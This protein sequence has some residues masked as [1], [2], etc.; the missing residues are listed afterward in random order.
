MTVAQQDIRGKMEIEQCRRDFPA[1]H[2]VD[3]DDTGSYRR[4]IHNHGA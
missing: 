3:I 4:T 1:L 2:I